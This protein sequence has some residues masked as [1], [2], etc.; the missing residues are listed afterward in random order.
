MQLVISMISIVIPAHNAAPT[1]RR[2]LDELLTDQGVLFEI[3]VVCN[4]CTDATVAVAEE[5]SSRVTIVTIPEASKVQALNAGD[6]A[7]SGWPRVYLDADVVIS[8]STITGLAA[9]L[10]RGYLAAAP[11]R[12]FDF[13]RSPW[14]V[15]AYYRVWERLPAV[16]TSL[17][18]RGAYALS[19]RGRE[20]FGAFPRVTN[21][22]GFI[23][24]LFTGAEKTVVAAPAL[25][26]APR[27]VR[28]LLRRRARIVLGN[29]ELRARGSGGLGPTRATDLFHVVRRDLTLL[30]PAMVYVALSAAGRIAARRRGVVQPDGSW[31]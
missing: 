29:E 12:Q 16:R 15:R 13:S 26:E 1:L 19:E 21:D 18:G 31:R 7:A 8:A 27:S 23:D 22:D 4:G 25:I 2:V 24:H 30:P 6:G 14:L 20:R 28:E 5:Y 9:Q 10:D 3:V 11:E 17:S